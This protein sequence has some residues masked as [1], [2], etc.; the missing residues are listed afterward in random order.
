MTNWMIISILTMGSTCG[1]HTHVGT[2]PL[3]TMS[4]LR[5]P[6]PC[7]KKLIRRQYINHTI[8]CMSCKRKAT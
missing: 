5:E 2:F 1:Y 7:G 6:L 4:T 3:G 8:Y